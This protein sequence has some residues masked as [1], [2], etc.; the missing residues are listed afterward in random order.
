MH[1]FL[2]YVKFLINSTNQHGVHSPFIYDFVIKCLYDK[3]NY[4]AYSHLKTYR[5]QLL[6][7][8]QTLNITDFGAGSKVMNSKKRS[9]S[10]MA[11]NSSSSLKDSKLL[12]RIANYFKFK[13]TLELG[14]SLGVGTQALALGHSNN[15]I[16]TIEGCPETF[17]FT[18]QQFE[19]LNLSNIRTINSD[20]K[21]AISQLKEDT[22]DC[23]FFDGHHNK[24]ATLE[25]F[26]LLIS[27]AH[28]DSL[29]I[30]DDIYWSKDMTEA[31]KDIV[32]DNRVTASIDTF[33]LGFAFFR[34]E[35]PKQHFRI[36]L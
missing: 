11:K 21:T 14:T 16:T 27:K 2:S 10:K 6:Q 35:Q 12:Y 36:R 4:E 24:A 22:F 13:N 32:N 20:F 1:Q 25:Y 9:V 8:K 29:F 34:K 17:K 26:N 31:W 30:F 7:S 18:K 19:A 33:N 28:N 23:I 3:T 15:K 5:N